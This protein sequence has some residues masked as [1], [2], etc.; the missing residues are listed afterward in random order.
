MSGVVVWLLLPSGSPLV[1]RLTPSERAPWSRSL[2]RRHRPAAALCVVTRRSRTQ[3][4]SRL[5][6]RASL[7]AVR[8]CGSY[9]QRAA[10]RC[11]SR[12]HGGVFAAAKMR[13][14]QRWKCVSR[15]PAARNTRSRRSGVYGWRSA[16]M[17]AGRTGAEGG[18]LTSSLARYA[19]AAGVNPDHRTRPAPAGYRLLLLF[20]GPSPHLQRPDADFPLSWA[21]CC[22]CCHARTPDSV[23]PRT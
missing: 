17:G 22:A 7:H 16:C 2:R 14:E 12:S 18:G 9:A 4:A 20:F 1:P 11:D 10:T 21:G 5:C 13:R 6:M 15:R 3:A 19:A 8:V 23:H